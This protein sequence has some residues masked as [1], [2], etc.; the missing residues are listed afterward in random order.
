MRYIIETT[1]P[2]ARARNISMTDNVADMFMAFIE[3]REPQR[4]EKVNDV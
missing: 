2:D 3:E 1:K 4:V